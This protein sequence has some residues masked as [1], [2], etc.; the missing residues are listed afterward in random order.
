MSVKEDISVA[1][2]TELRKWRK[3]NI[4]ID[5]VLL[6]VMMFLIAVIGSGM[7]GGM[8]LLEEGGNIRYHSF[9]QLMDINTDVIAWITM[10]GTHIDYPVVMSSDN[11]DYLDKGFDGEPYVGGTLFM[12]KDNTGPE[13]PY[14]IIYGHN[15]AVGAMFGD[16]KRY[17]EP[18]FFKKNN[19]GSLLTPEYDYRI[20][21]FAA[22]MFDAYDRI[23]YK[24][25]GTVPLEYIKK[26]ASIARDTDTT[27]HVLAL[28]TCMDDMSDN[29][30]VV[31]C[32]LNDRRKHRQD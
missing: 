10:D 30:A 27:D 3:I 7:I 31:F 9:S 14:C 26:N 13:D 20:E 25:G 8:A 18:D 6:P 4:W 29:R 15:M 21:V 1:M 23:I 16:L 17:L 12:D 2:D 11:Y 28:S 24:T 22:G 5:R 32:S 19:T